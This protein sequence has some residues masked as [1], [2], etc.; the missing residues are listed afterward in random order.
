MWSIIAGSPD[1]KVF[2]RFPIHLHSIAM[3]DSHHCTD[4]VQRCPNFSLF[5]SSSTSSL[6]SAKP[7]IAA[8]PT[9]PVHL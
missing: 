5:L 7:F 8:V 3:I 9:M 1:V 6:P 2:D 4:H